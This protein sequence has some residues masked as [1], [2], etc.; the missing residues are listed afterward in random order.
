MAFAKH[1]ENKNN[2][3]IYIYIYTCCVPIRLIAPLGEDK[4]IVVNVANSATMTVVK[5]VV[6][7][8]RAYHKLL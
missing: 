5:G 6:L 2:I 4:E 7:S 1:F 3:Y 8:D